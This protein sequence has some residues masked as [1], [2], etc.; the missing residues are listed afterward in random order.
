MIA[1]ALLNKMSRTEWELET[2]MFFLD[3]RGKS[4]ILA[5]ACEEC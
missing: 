1:K 2:V 5:L 4:A 3:R